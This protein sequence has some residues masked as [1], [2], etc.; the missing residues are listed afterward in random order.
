MWIW[1]ESFW[2]QFGVQSVQIEYDQLGLPPLIVDDYI[3]C[4]PN[5]EENNLGNV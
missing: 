2:G 4:R 1:T 5:M 3:Y